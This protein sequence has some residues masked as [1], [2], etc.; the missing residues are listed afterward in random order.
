MNFC[1]FVFR[2]FF[3]VNTGNSSNFIIAFKHIIKSRIFHICTYIFSF[4]SV[5]LVSIFQF[6]PSC[7]IL[8]LMVFIDGFWSI[9]RPCD[10]ADQ[11]P[12]GVPGE[13]HSP[14]GVCHR[15]GAHLPP[16]RELW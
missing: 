14:P 7:V 6:L 3:T 10:G 16:D 4:L 12:G 15:P 1:V 9:F 5:T 13:L 2:L 11:D 8:S